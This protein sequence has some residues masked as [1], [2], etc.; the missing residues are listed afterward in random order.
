MK[1]KT[2]F[3]IFKI[4]VLWKIFIRLI[5]GFIIAFFI[6]GI[7]TIFVRFDKMKSSAMSNSIEKNET[8]ITS[9]LRYAIAIKPFVSSLTGKTIIFSRPKRGD[10]IFMTDPRSS[11][12]N[13]I[14]RFF[15]YVIYFAT[16][17]NVNI[18]KKRYLIKRV[19]G[20][21]NETIEIREK[22]VYINGSFLEESWANINNDLRFLNSE[23]SGRDNFGPYIIGYNEYFVLSDNRDYGYDSRDF[24]S[25]NFSFINGKVINR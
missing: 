23:V 10:I 17:G 11:R 5:L 9:K 6:F 25:V 20:L 21:P 22:K 3:F 13:F 8:V 1:E 4:A 15:S 2:N 24:G 19:I 18:S 14:K 7:I 12:E 16:F